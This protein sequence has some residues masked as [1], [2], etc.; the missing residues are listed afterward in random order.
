MSGFTKDVNEE[1]LTFAIESM[2]DSN[3]RGEMKSAAEQL[4]RENG[5]D[6]LAEILCEQ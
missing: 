4:G 2:L 5:A 6:E 1:K 3:K